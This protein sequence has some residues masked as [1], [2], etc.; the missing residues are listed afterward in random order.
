MIEW[1]GVILFFARARVWY[2][3]GN[4]GG[5]SVN[6]GRK[7]RSSYRHVYGSKRRSNGSA[8][9]VTHE[10]RAMGERTYT[11]GALS[12]NYRTTTTT[13]PPPL[14][15]A[16][17]HCTCAHECVR[18]AFI[19]PR[20]AHERGR[21]YIGTARESARA[22]HDE[23]PPPPLR[24]GN[25][26]RGIPPRPFATRAYGLSRNG[27]KRKRRFFSPNVSRFI[28]SAYIGPIHHRRTCARV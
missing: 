24:R 1:R 19:A 14:W 15:F 21:R 6:D 18:I 2:R 12:R 20:R 11:A 22:V 3:K 16:V 5:I 4:L 9:C 26:L 10:P 8:V 23:P 7:K 25:N 17:F 13:R 28:P 27:T